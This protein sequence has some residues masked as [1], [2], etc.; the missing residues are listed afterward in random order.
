LADINH[1]LFRLIYVY[2]K[3]TNELLKFIAVGFNQRNSRNCK[4]ALAEIA[5]KIS[6]ISL[7]FLKT[8]NA[9]RIRAFVV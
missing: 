6:A 9:R 7:S 4:P 1:Y 5:G 2:K 8:T 3:L